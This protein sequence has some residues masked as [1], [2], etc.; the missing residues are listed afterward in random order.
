MELKPATTYD[1]QLKLLQERHCE[2]VD[3]A[4]CKT[5]LQHINYYR[6]TAYFLP[7]RTADGMYRDG[8][9]FHR[10][11][12]IYE[13]DRKMRRVMFSAV[14][15]VEYICGHSLLIFTHTSTALSA[16]WMRQITGPTTIMHA[17]GSCL[18]QK[19]NTTKQF[20]L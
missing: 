2:I 1:E 18:N 10:V 15:Q 12:R 14:E 20:H 13:F 4:F 5:V 16:I 6:F 9:S 7:F 3:P 17:F 19:Y 8:T 11:F